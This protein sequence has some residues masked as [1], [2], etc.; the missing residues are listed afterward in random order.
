MSRRRSGAGEPEVMAEPEAI[1]KTES[2]AETGGPQTDEAAPVIPD[3]KIPSRSPYELA[4]T[5]RNDI[6]E[7]M[8][9]APKRNDAT[10]MPAIVNLRCK[11]GDFHFMMP[12]FDA[13]TVNKLWLKYKGEVSPE[14]FVSYLYTTMGLNPPKLY[15]HMN[16]INIA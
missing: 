5:I 15:M 13:I 6:M 2:A 9:K 4:V 3:V 8:S 16:I 14:Q 7:T 1:P 10:T 11:T 12:Q